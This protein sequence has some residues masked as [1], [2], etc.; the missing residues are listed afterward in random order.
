MRELRSLKQWVGD[1]EKAKQ[2]TEELEV[3]Y[4]FHKS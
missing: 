1:Y 2:L 4:E 3:L